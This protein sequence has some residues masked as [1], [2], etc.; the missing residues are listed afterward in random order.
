MTNVII[1]DSVSKTII[2]STSSEKTY[3]TGNITT[4]KKIL[5]IHIE[6][7]DSEQVNDTWN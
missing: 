3:S 1:L 5:V 2:T 7:T 6:K 4:E